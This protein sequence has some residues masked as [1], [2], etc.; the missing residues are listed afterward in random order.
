MKIF[1]IVMGLFFCGVGVVEALAA[2]GI[3]TTAPSSFLLVCTCLVAGL[4]C[5]QDAMKGN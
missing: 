5:F 3:V 4:S 1:E 2:C